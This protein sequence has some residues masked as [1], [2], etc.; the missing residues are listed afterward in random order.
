L[1]DEEYY[2]ADLIGLQ[3]SDTGGDSLGTVKSVQNHGA[4]DLLEVQLPN[5]SST[6]LVPFTLAV[7]PMVDLRSGRIVI[8]PPEG[9]FPA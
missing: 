9:L 7:V 5:S 4:G 6:V 2:H 8:D 3:V 1:P